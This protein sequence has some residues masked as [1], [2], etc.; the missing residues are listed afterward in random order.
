[1]PHRQQV[2]AVVFIAAGLLLCEPISSAGTVENVAATEIQVA[3][4]GWSAVP[5]EVNPTQLPRQKTRFDGPPNKDVT[6]SKP[7]YQVKCGDTAA[8]EVCGDVPRQGSMI[9]STVLPVPV[10]PNPET[11]YCLRYR[12]RGIERSYSPVPVLAVTG[13]DAEGKPASQPLLTV[14]Q[15]LNDNRWHTIVGKKPFAFSVQ[16][17]RVQ[18]TTSNWLGAF[19]IGQLSFHSS[20]PEDNVQLVGPRSLD[21]AENAQFECIDL[22]DQFNDSFAASYRR[23]LDQNGVVVDSGIPQ[24]P[25]TGIPFKIAKGQQNLIRP[26]EDRN[27]NAEPVELLGT[28]TTRHFFKPHGRDDL[29]AIVIGK[30]ASEVFFVM[31]TESPLSEQCYARPAWPRPIDDIENVA[32]ELQ[33]ADGP[34]DFAFPYSLADAGFLVRRGVAAYVVPADPERELAGFVLHNRLFGKT[35]SLAA[36]TVNLSPARIVPGV[37]PAGSPIRVPVLP[38]PLQ[39]PQRQATIQREGDR[40]V[41]NNTFYEL[42]VDCSQGFSLQSLSN[43]WADADIEFHPSSGLEIEFDNTILTGRAFKTDSIEVEANSVTIRL[44]G[45]APEIPLSL[46]VQ[47]AID[48]TSQVT[49]NLAAENTGARPFEADVRFP[50]LRDMTIDDCENTWLFF[51][52]YR[53]VITN[54]HGIYFAP[55]DTRFPMQVCDIYNPHAGIGLAVLTHNRDH[56]SLDYSMSKD[57]RGASAFVQAPGEL[58]R[59]GPSESVAFT[60]SCLV[61][62]SGDWHEAVRAYRDWLDSVS[63]TSV[64]QKK[65]WFRRTFIL[66]NHQMKKFYAWSTPIY[67]AETKT[68][69][70]DDC[71]RTDTDYLGMKPDIF[72]FFGWI[73]LDNGWHGHPNGDFRVEGYTGGP[74]K[75]KEA[76]RSLQEEH[77]IPTSLY[78]LSDRCYKKSEFGKKHGEQ[79]AIQRKDG[80][81]VQDEANWFLC[82][83][84]QGW[85][86]QYVEALCR[87]QRE[88]GVKILYVDV[89]PFSRS[90]ACYSPDHGHKIPSHVNRGTYALIRQLRESLPDDVI[91]WSEY[92]LPDMSLPYIDGNIHYYCLDWHEHFGKLYNQ[93]EEARPFAATPTNV[94][95]YVFPNLKQFVFPCGV[96][97]Y[98][99]DTKFPFFNGEALYDCSWCL[100]A[101][102]HLERIKKSLTIQR[103][104]ADCFASPHATPEVATL[105]QH[106]HANRFP[107]DGRTAWTFFNARYTTVRGPVIAVDHHEGATYH[108]VWN[109][110]PLEPT[111]TDGRAS[112]SLTLHPQQLGCIIE[113]FKKD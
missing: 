18:V 1:M 56:S 61:F 99:G 106:V 70:I 22:S 94:Y 92:P 40:V 32:V 79:L 51:P 95:R 67:D 12:A 74:E 59:I 113:S 7:A 57:D 53:N 34:C 66:R 43:R 23:V 16:A 6:S 80:S 78:T 82:G 102:P 2:R 107:G 31:V 62:H 91:L 97:P 29:T 100:Y 111:I 93:L 20:L 30:Q 15:V 45:L 5:D 28:K 63:E 27:P 54:R 35:F 84:S 26:Q 64:A 103:Q 73:D 101:S 55:N 72:H 42:V 47:L 89:F 38:Q 33:Y 98:S 4:L 17:L 104:Y 24:T 52:Q 19:E 85:R 75:L 44:T 86:D 48:D 71:V 9:W 87:T 14:D 39:P 77:G 41:L 25:S 50:V 11:Y 36:V 76:I 110:T 8:F 88:T 13:K 108:D 83:N 68:Y 65:D 3:S 58:Y 109:D 105:Q 60:E 90:S 49:M 10:S 69:C 46:N 112:L 81:L 21:R 96:S 37:L